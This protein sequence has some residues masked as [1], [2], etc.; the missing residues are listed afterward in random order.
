MPAASSRGGRSSPACAAWEWRCGRTTAALPQIDVAAFLES[1]AEAVSLPGKVH[2]GGDQPGCFAGRRRRHRTHCGRV[3]GALRWPRRSVS[4][5]RR[6]LGSCPL[7]EVAHGIATLADHDAGRHSPDGR[8][9]GPGLTM[10]EHANL[11]R[12]SHAARG[13]GHRHAGDFRPGRLGDHAPA[14]STAW[15]GAA[16]CERR[17]QASSGSAGLASKK[18][19]QDQVVLAVKSPTGWRFTAT[20][21]S[22]WC[23]TWKTLLHAQGAHV[24]PWTELVSR[25]CVSPLAGAGAGDAGPGADGVERRALHW[26]NITGR[27]SGR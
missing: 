13:R 26:I 11:Y 5:R 16:A 22:R 17:R 23:A 1:T 20:A 15:R 27:S 10:S 12:L 7:S 4:G 8:S 18:W 2:S 14:V 9:P 24:R 6:R 25:Q 21:A 3:Y 19:Q